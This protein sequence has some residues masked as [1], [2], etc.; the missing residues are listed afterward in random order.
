[1]PTK[2]ELLAFADDVGVSVSSAMTKAEI[3]GALHDAG[4]NPETLSPEDAS[5]TDTTDTG[6]TGVSEAHA[7]ALE[8]GYHGETPDEI[9]NEAYPIQG[10]GEETAQREREQLAALKTA[11]LKTDGA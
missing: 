1:M 5:V 6:D 7:E 2:D 4:Y 9:E 11:A 3:E 10:Q 8:K